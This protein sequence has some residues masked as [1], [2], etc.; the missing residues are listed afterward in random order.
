MATDAPLFLSDSHQ[1]DIPA[2][3]LAG[4]ARA[5]ARHSM[6]TPEWYTPRVYVEAARSVLGGIDLDPA[7]CEEA[8]VTIRASRIYT[9]EDDGIMQ[10]WLGR[11]FVNPPGGRDGAGK[12]LVPQF[13]RKF[14]TES[15]DAGIWIGYSLEQLQTLQ[16]HGGPHPMDYSMCIPRKRIAFN[17]PGGDGKK[18]PSHANY[19]VYRGMFTSLFLDVFSQFGRVR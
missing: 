7:S 16:T 10:P 17:S 4:E 11:V 3:S 15:I 13:W 12:S 2:E 1:L 8:N 18:Q 9:V 19:I 5:N 6:G 14:T